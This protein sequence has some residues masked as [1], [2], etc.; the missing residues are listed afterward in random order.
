MRIEKHAEQLKKE[1]SNYC[2]A[3]DIAGSL[4][5]KVP[6]ARDIDYICIPIDKEKL[7]EYLKKKYPVYRAGKKLVSFEVMGIFIDLFFADKINYGAML[8]FLTGTK[9]SNIGMR[10]IAKKKG[11]KLNQYGLWRG[12]ELIA[13]ETEEDIYKALGRS[14]KLPELR[15]K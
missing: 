11:F 5:R 13:S 7:I 6:N 4:R 3:I 9:G 14:F 10:V 2:V 12:K 8:L 1:L 15:G